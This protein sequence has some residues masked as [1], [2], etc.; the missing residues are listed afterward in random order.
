MR[1][2]G[3]E[4]GGFSPYP[5]QM[6]EASASWFILP[7]AGTHARLLDPCCGEGVITNL[8][9]G[10]LNCDT[11]RDEP[12]GEAWGCE[13]F[14]Y[15][16]EKAAANLDKCHSAAGENYSLTDESGTLLWLNATLR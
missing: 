13:L 1:L 11:L 3:I 14:P 7:L 8:V 12:Q 2:A 15:R 5:T 4:K 16:A 10:L 9:G 6:A